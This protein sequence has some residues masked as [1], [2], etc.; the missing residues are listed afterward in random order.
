MDVKDFLITYP[1]Y[2]NSNFENIIFHLKEFYDDKLI[3]NIK[4]NA[5]RIMESSKNIS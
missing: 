4:K 1:E 5:K 3:K 2:S